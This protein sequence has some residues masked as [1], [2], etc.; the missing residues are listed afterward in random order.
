[1]YFLRKSK[2]QLIPFLIILHKK[3]KKKRKQQQKKKQNLTKTSSSSCFLNFFLVSYWKTRKHV[4]RESLK[5]R[6]YSQ[7]QRCGTKLKRESE[8][9]EESCRMEFYLGLQSKRDLEERFILIYNE[10]RTIPPLLCVCVSELRKRLKPWRWMN[11]DWKQ[12]THPYD[13]WDFL[14]LVSPP[15]SGSPKNFSWL[16][17]RAIWVLNDHSLHYTLLGTRQEILLS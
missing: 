17:L 8:K 9:E 2:S 16:I 13:S 10:K 15:S 7:K 12:H 4:V 1:M 5:E 3:K 14:I 11:Q 6:K